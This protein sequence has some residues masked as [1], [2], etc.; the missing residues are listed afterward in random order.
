[1]SLKVINLMSGV[2]ETRILVPH[3]SSECKCKWNKSLCNLKQRWDQ[4]KC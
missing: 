4:D 2:N 3:E 1:M